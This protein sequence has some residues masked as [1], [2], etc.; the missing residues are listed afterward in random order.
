MSF[1][2]EEIVT[3]DST[4]ADAKGRLGEAA[5][6]IREVVR[7]HPRLFLIAVLGAAL[8]A[9]CT[10]ASSIGLK[11]MI[12]RVILVRFESGKIDLGA[13][14]A[15]SVIVIGIG[16]LRA[17]GVVIRRS[18]AGRTEWRTCETITEKVI[19]HIVG[20]PIKWHRQKMTGDIVARCGVDADASVAILAPLPFSTS[21]VVMM[22]VSASWML[23]V[24][25]PLG[26][27]A[28]IVFPILL[29]LN[30]GYQR[31]ID[32][33]Y[34][35]A[36]KELGTLSEAV[37]E[38]F[39]GVMVVKS[40]GA[41]VRETE[42]LAKISLRLKDAR[43]SAIGVRSV[44]EA[45]LDVVPTLIN[46]LLI[47]LG[48]YRVKAGEMSV[49]DLSSFIYLFTLLIFPLR[50]IGY[51]FSEIPHS[52]AGWRRIC[53]VLDEQI[54]D[55]PNLKIHRASD[56]IAIEI[57]ELCFSHQD[58]TQVL[59]DLS[60]KIES[61]KIVALVGATGSGKSTLL[62]L[63]SGLIEP[64]SGSVAVQ[65]GG[66]ALV[67]QEA[68]LFAESLRYNITLDS[69]ISTERV[70]KA[71][72]TAQC[73]DFVSD[74]E[75][76]LETVMGERGVSLSGGQRQRVALARAI[77]HDRPVLLL[78][79]TTSALDP[80]TESNVIGGLRGISTGHTLLIVASRP[81]TIAL[82]D[83]VLFMA[84]GRIVDRGTHE[85]L[86]KKS[87]HYRLL[88]SAFEHDRKEL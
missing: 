9:V 49:G 86:L 82:A 73:Q 28:V 79:D 41:E 29:A 27:L 23:Y 44:F 68:F 6:L 18:F 59:N 13:L 37:H 71:I 74:L 51:L 53:E 61:G 36:Q 38:S 31:R 70:M 46:I 48:A 15:G 54:L 24:D 58:G 76:G 7:F 19:D 88:I 81:S 75:Q 60:M 78:D 65:E 64:S 26:L 66:V 42:R 84:D 72:T 14:V 16:L 35:A 52:V 40:F 47:V 77:A 67:F 17:L 20:Q 2:D 8:F 83:E 63:I 30:I 32:R 5:Q 33:F 12:D 69:D 62:H 50:I 45:M 80:K 56:G 22:V 21:V 85:S 1:V 87:E 34:N 43:I 39:D 3:R 4:K 25:I 57:R 10:V 55:D 11:W